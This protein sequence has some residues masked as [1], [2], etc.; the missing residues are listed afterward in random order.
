M[1][2]IFMNNVYYNIICFISEDPI[3]LNDLKNKIINC[4]FNNKTNF[5]E[6]FS[7]Y[8]VDT[9]ILLSEDYNINCFICESSLNIEYNKTT[10]KFYFYVDCD[11]Y[12][13]IPIKLLDEFTNNCCLGVGYLLKSIIDEITVVFNSDTDN[14]YFS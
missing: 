1:V 12:N 5:T 7:L 13:D 11:S 14:I 8:G 3:L 2:T 10:D 6:I 9:D 4:L